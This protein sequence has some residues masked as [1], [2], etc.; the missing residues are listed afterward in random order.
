[1]ARAGGVLRVMEAFWRLV[2]LSEPH[3]TL[4]FRTPSV[5]L[6]NTPVRL[7]YNW[8]RHARVVELVDTHG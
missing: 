4:Y 7:G 5:L 1:M 6:D 3:R 2:G 8:V